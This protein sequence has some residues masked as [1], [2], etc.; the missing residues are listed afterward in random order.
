MKEVKLVQCKLCGAWV[1][2]A[3]LEAHIKK[4]HSSDGGVGGT[5]SPQSVFGVR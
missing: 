3:D 5:I 2:V 1:A 4:Y